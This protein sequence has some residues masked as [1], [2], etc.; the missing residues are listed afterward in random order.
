MPDLAVGK[1]VKVKGNVEFQA[2]DGE[3]SLMV[4]R[5]NEIEAPPGVQ[6]LAAVK[7]VEFHLHTKMS[8]LDGTIDVEDVVK[9]SCRMGA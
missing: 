8:G 6:D 2:F 5:I 1:W 9:T 4:Q 3:L 7:R